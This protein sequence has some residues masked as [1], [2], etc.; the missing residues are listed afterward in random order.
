M[1]KKIAK[2]NPGGPPATAAGADDLL[3]DVRRMIEEARQQVAATVN[4]AL[5]SLYWRIGKRTG[6]ELLGG[7]RAAYGE[8]IVSTL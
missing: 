2:R 8:E 1:T 6:T 7:E 3:R 4:V 5:T